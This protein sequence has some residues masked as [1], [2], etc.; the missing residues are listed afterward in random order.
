MSSKIKVRQVLHGYSDGHR[1][2]AASVALKSRDLRTMLILSDISGPGALVC[3]KGYLTGYPLQE[4]GAYAIARTWAADEM[5]RP[6][7]VWT[8]TLLIDFADLA[9]LESMSWLSTVFKRPAATSYA[10]YEKTIVVS[11][12]DSI[13]DHIQGT[14]T[15]T[16]RIFESLYG[17]P[18][19]RII[20]VRPLDIDVDRLVLEIWFQQ[21]PRLR[22]SFRFCTMAATDRTTDGAI[23]D[24]QLLPEG[25]RNIRSR[26]KDTLD[27]QNATLSTAPWIDQALW[28]LAHP[29]SFGLRKFFR[30][31]GAD[32]ST[33]REA[34]RP[35]CQLHHALNIQPADSDWI[36]TAITVLNNELDVTQA[37]GARAMVI[38]RL[39]T[40]SRDFDKKSLAFLLENIDCI[41]QF[42]DPQ[43]RERLGKALWH[44]DI[45][46][47]VDL[48]A[49]KTL[50]GEVVNSTFSL[51]SSHEIIEG[52]KQKNGLDAI[53]MT[54]KPEILSHEEFWELESTDLELALDLI[55]SSQELSRSAI[56][57]MLPMNRP[58]LQSAVMRRLGSSAVIEAIDSFLRVGSKEI[59]LGWID[60]ITLQSAEVEDYLAGRSCKSMKFLFLLA[61]RLSPF[62]AGFEHTDPWLNAYQTASVSINSTEMTFLRAYLLSRSIL[63]R[64]ESAGH[65]A[66]LT[67]DHLFQAVQSEEMPEPAWDVLTKCLLVPSGIQLNNKK[68]RLLASIATLFVDRNISPV[69]F[70]SLTKNSHSFS[71]LATVTARVWTGKSYLKQ[72]LKAMPNAGF[73]S[74][75]PWAVELERCIRLK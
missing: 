11:P 57:A 23:F 75:H 68:A 60:A 5:P 65:I 30:A 14:N 39:F 35:L 8:H 55:A 21:W 18:R 24:L 3:D 48:L 46:Y 70:L 13:E 32:V 61:Q 31:V 2:L 49:S 27:A 25:E 9:A 7:C 73:A 62:F 47:F 4:L 33:G 74:N 72:V 15:W 63:N 10:D 67:F 44:I 52:I 45:D 64:S 71:E 22:R 12:G 37:R 38:N 66:I 36:E 40:D 28:D 17:S 41:E 69:L 53:A 58:W 26:F 54:R 59:Y 56:A 16:N 19:N 50:L 43:R 42:L 6:G 20:S 1:Q 34:F 51:L 29:D